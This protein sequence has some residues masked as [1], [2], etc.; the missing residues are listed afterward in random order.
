MYDITKYG[1][2]N[3]S[4]VTEAL[5]NAIDEANT[6]GGGTVYIPPGD[7]Y[8]GTV[9]LKSFITLYLD[10]GAVL[11]GTEKLEDYRKIGYFHNEMGEV[12]SMLYAVDAK[13]I[14]IRGEGVI[15]LNGNGFYDPARPIVPPHMVG[16]ATEAQIAQCTW[17]HEARVNQPIFFLRCQDISFEG[18][19]ITNA[20]CWT[21][22][23]AQCRRITV[24]GITIQNHPNIPNN[25]GLHFC[26][27]SDIIIS[28]CHIFSADDCIAVTAI[29]DWE[30][31]SENIIISNCV[32]HSYS[33]AIV[34]GYMHSIIRN[35]TISNCVIKDSNRGITIVSSEGSGLVENVTVVNCVIDT[36]VR[37]G[38]WW[39][40]GEPI[41]I[42][43][44]Y[45]HAYEKTPQHAYRVNVRGIH[46]SSLV[47]SAEN[48]I[49]I[50]GSHDNIEDVRLRDISFTPKESENMALK[51][52]IMDLSPSRQT[53][54]VPDDGHFYWLV[55]RNA[56][57]V[58]VEGAS[59]GPYKG[60]TPAA[61]MEE[62]ARA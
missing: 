10:N 38:N 26:G 55:A 47:I 7:Y 22:T 17:Y 23:F 30:I 21:L 43:G 59:V 33:K 29:T 28:D 52:R 36:C 48:G 62:N 16:R 60:V 58:R 51:G 31:P 13:N 20:P 8:F 34:L 42:M 1:A 54:T 35:V 49:G 41:F 19:T 12:T 15:D 50:I 4:N 37:A 40:N 24:H 32:L 2:V 5:Q 6:Y 18:V 46:F 27:S 45:H 25:D 3:G 39:G 14:H 9:K 56:N 61:F 57:H 11:R 44:T 53:E